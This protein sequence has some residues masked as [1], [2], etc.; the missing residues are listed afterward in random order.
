MITKKDLPKSTPD[1]KNNYVFS[2]KVKK[3][4]FSV[5]ARN[6]N[7]ESFNGLM[8]SKLSH[9]LGELLLFAGGFVLLFSGVYALM[10]WWRTIPQFDFWG[11]MGS[12]ILF[13]ITIPLAPIYLG[14]NGDWGPTVVFIFTMVLG[15]LLLKIG[16]KLYKVDLASIVPAR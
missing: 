11:F 4:V 16:S 2:A 13:P 12:V 6:S 1:K 5:I 8:I 15:G 7:K 10:I 3:Y 9:L 14:V